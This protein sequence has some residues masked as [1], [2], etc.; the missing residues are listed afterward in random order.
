MSIR[1]LILRGLKGGL[2]YLPTRGLL[3]AA[4]STP[5]VFLG[6]AGITTFY[7]GSAP[8]TKIYLGSTQIV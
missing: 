8:V 5:T 3:P 2:R 6:S 7:I 1:A 4:S